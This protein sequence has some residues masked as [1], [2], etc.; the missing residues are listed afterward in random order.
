MAVST[1]VWG[2]DIGQCA[3]KA[4]RCK[5]GEDGETVI[6]DAFDYI[7][8]PKIL[9]QPEAN[10]EELIHEALE[11]FLSRN[12]V[13]GDRVA[14]SVSGQSG[15]ARFFKPPPVEAKKIPDIVKYE[16][17]QQIPFA[18]EEVIWD[19]QQMPGGAEE[20]GVALDTEVGLFAMKREHVFR[21]LEPFEDVGIEL[22]IVQLSPLC[23]YN[24]AAYDLLT[25]GPSPDDYDPEDPPDSIVILSM[26]TDST[27]LVV[28]N[29]FRVWQRSIPLGGNHFT[30]QLTSELKLTFAKAE[31]LKRNARQA[32]DP[33]TVF[34]AMRSVFNDMVTEVQRSIS[35]FQ[36]IDRTA[37]IAKVMA[38]GNATK[39]PGLQQYLAANLGLEVGRIDK[40]HRLTGPGVVASGAF[41]DNLLAFPVCYG[42]CL[43]GLGKANLYTSLL[44]Q[45]ILTNRLIREKKPW[46]VACVALAYLAFCGYFALQMR[47]WRSSDLDTK[48]WQQ[49]LN[50]VQDTTRLSQ[51]HQ[52][53]YRQ[54]TE[55][56]ERL[57]D[58]GDLVVGTA[59]RR[60]LWP[61]LIKTIDSCMPRDPSIP[62][63]EVSDKPLMQRPD[64]YIEAIDSQPF[65]DLAK[66]FSSDIR[67]KYETDGKVIFDEEADAST[68]EPA[69]A[70]GDEP[71]DDVAADASDAAEAPD[72]PD[73]PT[74]KGWVIELRGHHY[75]NEDMSNQGAQ[76]VRKTLIKNL[77][78]GSVRLPDGPGGA[79]EDLTTKE[80]GV[81]FPVLVECTEPNDIPNPILEAK[82]E[83]ATGFGSEEFGEGEFGGAHGFGAGSGFG[84]PAAPPRAANGES[85]PVIDPDIPRFVKKCNF[86]VQF[87]WQGTTASQRREIEKKRRL[88]EQEQ[89]DAAAAGG[90]GGF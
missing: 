88:A 43:Q 14:I 25:D 76:Y 65:D 40:F 28:T 72:E 69:A 31:H 33:K 24:F 16:A 17:R 47:E 11:Q 89:A 38:V 83:S 36:S 10:R 34:K 3:L 81:S 1:A 29:G 8:Y 75:H 35:Y 70:D 23:I 55:E 66:W 77:R 48:E 2:I 20:E 6:A 74:G 80:L 82:S 32:E 71:T 30:R 26:G 86:T 68:E 22:D 37:K 90:D 87:C 21:A 27:D 7:E 4:L 15:L 49:A 63:E 60:L 51:G 58:I 56:V 9:S 54:K 52:E 62:A 46:A 57:N 18:L 44:P 67:E 41:K 42:L 61:E 85:E 12:T 5:L 50:A 73:G 59:E 45:E 79:F 13:K 84:Q 19:F 53:T 78:T 39:L 64:V